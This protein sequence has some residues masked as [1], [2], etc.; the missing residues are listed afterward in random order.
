M[1]LFIGISI[2]SHI[3]HTIHA[4]SLRLQEISSGKYVREDMYHITLAYIGES[5][6]EM[7]I[8]ATECVNRAAESASSA[9][10]RP[11][12]PD[13]FGKPEKAILHLN[14]ENGAALEYANSVLRKY[15]SEAGLPFDPKP[16]VP[17]I[18]LA[19]N[20]TV[21][22]ILLAEKYEHAPFYA[23]GL[24]LFNSCRI[25]DVLQYIPIHFAP[26]GGDI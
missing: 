12:V 20:T 3:R 8:S 14:V 9:L 18:T 17:H 1:R 24:T 10:L 21:T 5:D 22:P 26:F 19:R 16:L 13:F 7:L 11:G 2:P 23:T 4:H 6:E 15:L 25:D